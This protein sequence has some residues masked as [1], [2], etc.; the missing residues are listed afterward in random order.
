MNINWYPG[1]MKKTRELIE[2]HIKLVDVVIEILDARVPISSMNPV[3]AEIIGSKPRLVLLN[4]CDLCD[5]QALEEWVDHFKTQGVRAVPVN[6]MSGEGARQVIKE[7]KII[8]RDIVKKMKTKM[9]SARSIRVMIV[10]IPNVGKSSLINRLIGKQKAKTGNKPGVTKD[11]QWVR[12]HKDF[13]LMDTPGIL[14]PKRDDPDCGVHLALTGA[15]KDEVFDEEELAFVLV[16]KMAQSYPHVLR[17]RFDIADPSDDPMQNIEKIAKRR[18]CL[19]KGNRFDF[20]KTAK[21]IIND[22][23]KGMFGNLVLE[24]PLDLKNR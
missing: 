21:L 1:H 6:S 19:L 14:W 11:K 17:D 20:P 23:R 4:K 5:P 22:Y 7:L 3:L 18:G 10:G 16:E 24:R 9:R 15:I 8:S 13:D 2:A 12:I